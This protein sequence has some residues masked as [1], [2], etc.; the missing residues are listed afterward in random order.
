M[1]Y[2]SQ[3][4]CEIYNKSVKSLHTI[5]HSYPSAYKKE[6]HPEIWKYNEV[7]KTLY[8]TLICI[9]YINTYI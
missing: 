7:I 5:F 3:K 9:L 4:F 6:V 1:S 2:P 8:F